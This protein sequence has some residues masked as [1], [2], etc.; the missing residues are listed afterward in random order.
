MPVPIAV[1]VPVAVGAGIAIV[2]GIVLP[3][4]VTSSAS[5]SP[6]SASAIS[7]LLLPLS[8][9]SGP[10]AIRLS[11][12]LFA[13]EV[14]P[15][16]W[17]V[18]PASPLLLLSG[19]SLVAS[20]FFG[21]QLLNAMW[22]PLQ[23]GHFSCV[24]ER[25]LLCNA[26]YNVAPMAAGAVWPWA[27]AACWFATALALYV[28]PSAAM[29]TSTVWAYI[30]EWFGLVP[31]SRR[32]DALF[33]QSPCHLVPLNNKDDW[34]CGDLP[35]LSP[36]PDAVRVRLPTH[37]DG[38]HNYF[39]LNMNLVPHHLLALSAFAH[40]P[41]EWYCMDFEPLTGFGFC[42]GGH[43]LVDPTCCVDDSIVVHQCHCHFRFLVGDRHDS[44]VRI[45]LRVHYPDVGQFL[46]VEKRSVDC[47]WNLLVHLVGQR[48]T[49]VSC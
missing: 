46:Q 11:A 48:Y 40:V 16:V 41:H 21:H 47:R 26:P 42:N 23:L 44:T 38:D 6:F 37:I 20:A 24:W 31:H 35:L 33:D 5:I 15:I 12:V 4:I 2:V 1:A 18:S 17:V 13:P 19:A 14:I 36:L 8:A 39:V 27:V 9:P 34:Q 49:L 25:A 22:F 32:L 3:A 45:T 43:A 7:S 28:A 10:L 29:L 30:H